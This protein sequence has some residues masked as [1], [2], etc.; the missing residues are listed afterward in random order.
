[1]DFCGVLKGMSFCKAG[2]ETCH[3]KYAQMTFLEQVGSMSMTWGD[4]SDFRR[5]LEG[6]SF[7]KANPKTCHKKCAPRAFLKKWGAGPRTGGTYLIFAGSWQEAH[8]AGRVQKP[9]T[10]HVPKEHFGKNGEQV[11]HLRGL[12]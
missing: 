12:I 5:V 11:R 9:V 4:L 7:G 2:P 10:R 3:K 6:R 8:F 1:M